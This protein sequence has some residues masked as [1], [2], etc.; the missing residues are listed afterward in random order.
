MP[1]IVGIEG[2]KF[3]FAHI[4]CPHD[5]LVFGPNGEE[6][7]FRDS[8]FSLRKSLYLGQFIFITK[9]IDRLI[10]DI[11]SRSKNL[12]IIVIQSDHGIRGT[13]GSPNQIFNSYYLP[14]KGTN[15][16]YEN[17]SPVNTFRLILNQYYNGKYELLPD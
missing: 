12:P 1:A 9:K 17:I 14:G 15:L 16:M 6:I 2:P 5:P 11:L 8:S 7:S 10:D 3:V 4:L 13:V